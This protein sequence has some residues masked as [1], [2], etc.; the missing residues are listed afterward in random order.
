LVKTIDLYLLI[1]KNAKLHNLNNC[2]LSKLAGNFIYLFKSVAK[3]VIIMHNL[4]KGV[5]IVDNKKYFS[6]NKPSIH[7]F[8]VLAFANI[9]IS[10]NELG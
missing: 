8:T 10:F 1:V 2:N 9:Y 3:L 4:K 5:I 6:L 7:P